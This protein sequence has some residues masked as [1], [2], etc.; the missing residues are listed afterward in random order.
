MRR[1]R[2]DDPDDAGSTYPARAHPEDNEFRDDEANVQTFMSKRTR[3]DRLTPLTF[4]FFLNDDETIPATHDDYE[5]VDNFY[6][7]SQDVVKRQNVLNTIRDLA[8]TTRDPA[9]TD[10]LLLV[11]SGEYDLDYFDI[12]DE[13]RQRITVTYMQL[14][15]QPGEWSCTTDSNV[16]LNPGSTYTWLNTRPRITGLMIQADGLTMIIGAH[17]KE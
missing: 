11:A 8:K 16:I 4:H 12:S 3:T 15:P 6:F 17:R 7:E 13:D 5:I 14:N 2:E 1:A 10:Y 9:L